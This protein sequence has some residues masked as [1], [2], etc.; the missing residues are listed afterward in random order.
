M[1]KA[2]IATAAA[3]VAAAVCWSDAR[4]LDR[5][6]SEI[7]NVYLYCDGR[8]NARNIAMLS[9]AARNIRSAS[10]LLVIRRSS[11]YERAASIVEGP[12]MMLEMDK[13]MI[14][15]RKEQMV[16]APATEV[17]KIKNEVLEDFNRKD[18]LSS[19]ETVEQ[20][21]RDLRYLQI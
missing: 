12:V 17:Q 21:K 14:D 18:E 3:L 9:D 11:R 8:P 5:I 16:E 1:K 20:M 13:E 7:D 15:G 4:N 6:R 2:I 10:R 19:R